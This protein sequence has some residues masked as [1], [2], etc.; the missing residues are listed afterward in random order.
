MALNFSEKLNRFAQHLFS[1]PLQ[2]PQNLIRPIQAVAAL[3]HHFFQN[4]QNLQTYQNHGKTAAMLPI[5]PLK[6]RPANGQKIITA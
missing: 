3:P 5:C 2:H 4:A 1:S 6:K